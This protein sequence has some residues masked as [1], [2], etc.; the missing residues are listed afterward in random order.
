M[1]DCRSMMLHEKTISLVALTKGM[2]LKIMARGKK[3]HESC[4]F[5]NSFARSFPERIT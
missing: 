4:K 2:A 3:S 1:R 5:W